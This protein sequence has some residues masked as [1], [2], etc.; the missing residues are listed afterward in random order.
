MGKYPWSGK[1]TLEHCGII[2]KIAPIM[3]RP[4]Q[5]NGQ[6]EGYQSQEKEEPIEVCKR[7]RMNMRNKEE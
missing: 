1:R 3:G 5:E 4:R 2:T 7:C 6:C